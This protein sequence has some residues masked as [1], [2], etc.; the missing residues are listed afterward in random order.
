MSYTVYTIA[1]AAGKFQFDTVMR[2]NVTAKKLAC[3]SDEMFEE[4]NYNEEAKSVVCASTR[5]LQF[6]YAI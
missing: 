2:I 3:R 5:R 6:I 1:V 4:N